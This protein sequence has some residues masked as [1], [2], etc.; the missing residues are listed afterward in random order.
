VLFDYRW[1]Q[2]HGTACFFTDENSG[3]SVMNG[4]ERLEDAV[5]RHVAAHDSHLGQ[6]RAVARAAD[7]LCLTTA[8]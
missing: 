4:S 7:R 3:C 2:R 6:E 1:R 5:C 8:E